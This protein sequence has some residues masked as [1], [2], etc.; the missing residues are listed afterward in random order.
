[1]DDVRFIIRIVLNGSLISQSS[2]DQGTDGKEVFGQ[3]IH[4]SEIP[5][6]WICTGVGLIRPL[7]AGAELYER[8]PL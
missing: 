1:M 8:P 6:Q 3:Q 5:Y 2:S 4:R 7:D